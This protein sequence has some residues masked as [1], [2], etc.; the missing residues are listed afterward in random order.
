MTEN[1]AEKLRVCP[2]CLR[3]IESREGSQAAELNYYDDDDETAICDWC[4]EWSDELYT[5]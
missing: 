2:H 3:A 5:I 1:T 4:G